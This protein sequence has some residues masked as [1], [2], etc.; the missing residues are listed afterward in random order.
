M[1]KLMQDNDIHP[2]IADKFALNEI[3][4]AHEL[5]E[6]RRQIGKIVVTV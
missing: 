1:I 6:K 3:S 2:V 4:K 5:A